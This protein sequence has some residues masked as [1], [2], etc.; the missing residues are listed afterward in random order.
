MTVAEAATTPSI[1][2]RTIPPFERHPRIFGMLE[3]L[4]SE[5]SFI[6]VSDH[7]PRPLH[8]QIQHNYPQLFAWEYIEQG[9]QVWRVMI[10]REAS[11]CCGG[12]CG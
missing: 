1:D 12:G 4:K 10:T 3:S 6:V 5:Q 2:V 7:D 9:P 11:E 8:Y